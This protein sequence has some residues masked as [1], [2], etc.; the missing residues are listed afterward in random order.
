MLDI[1][2]HLSVSTWIARY[3]ET[4]TNVKE[5]TRCNLNWLGCACTEVFETGCTDDVRSLTVEVSSEP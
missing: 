2:G 5:S 1:F 4:L 3:Y